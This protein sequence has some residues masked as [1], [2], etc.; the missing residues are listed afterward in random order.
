M[1]S[2]YLLVILI[3]FCLTSKEPDEKRVLNF[4]II[5]DVRS[6]CEE[7][8]GLVKQFPNSEKCW[9]VYLQA[10]AKR[11]EPHQMLKAW[12][13]FIERF[14]DRR[15][16]RFL[17]ESM[18]WG[19]IENNAASRSP[20]IRSYALLGA[21]Y[22]QDARGVKIIRKAFQDPNLAVRTLAVKMS[23]YLRDDSL[24][25][26]VLNLLKNEKNLQVRLE[27]I[28]T[29]GKMKMR[30][31]EPYLLRTLQSPGSRA[32]E[33]LT[34]IQALVSLYDQ[35]SLSQ[36]KAL[37]GS[38]RAALRELACRVVL[39]TEMTEAVPAV[40]TLLNDS[41]PDVKCAALETLGYLRVNQ[42]A[43]IA[44]RIEELANDPNPRVSI[45]ASWA[46][47]FSD[48]DTAFSF[49]RRH[50]EGNHRD[51]QLLAGA[52]LVS[53]GQYG[54][55][56]LEKA[57]EKSQDE[58]LKMNLAL[59]LIVNGCQVEE[60]CRFLVSGFINGREQWMW[61][62]QGVFRFLAPSD[63][64]HVPWIPNHPEMVNQ[65]TRLEILNILAIKESPDALEA[66]KSFLSRR[67]WGIS[68]MAS[69]LLLQEGDESAIEL[70][71]SLLSDPSPRVRVQAALI[72][73]MWG[74]D[75]AS[76]EELQENYHKSDRELKERILEGLGNVGS[77]HSLP[78]LTQRLGDPQPSLKVI[79]AASLL[80]CLYH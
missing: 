7:G 5:D 2:L 80:Q 78:F 8:N 42:N 66:A 49:L 6:A 74:G 50:L 26:E 23:S 29:A 60:S 67:Q 16:D 79:A 55:T 56:F 43:E 51:Y 52:A 53:S 9:E 20:I 19:V 45:S 3:P 24:Q 18:A 68:G 48:A 62:Q 25:D 10:L 65:M 15:E 33:K 73:S 14:P 76:V 46:L 61:K 13:Q 57:F 1:R 31:A 40:A 72:L 41:S 77:K 36:V 4:L 34:V 44:K 27:A 47:M 64:K 28:E 59:G 37:M 35:L 58:F 30:N 71:Q 11:G 75:E 38:Q 63:V 22:G 21:F 70:V 32:E 12:D 39:H 69:S 54:S 17:L